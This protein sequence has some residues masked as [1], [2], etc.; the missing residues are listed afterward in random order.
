M[1]TK[2]LTCLAVV[3][4]VVGGNASATPAGPARTDASAVIDGR[5][6]VEPAHTRVQFSVS[7]MGFTHWY[8]DLTEA[9]GS[10]VLDAKDPTASKVEISLPVASV[11]TT[12]SKLD[13]ELRGAQWLDAPTYPTVTFVSTRIV[14]TGFHTAT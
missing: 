6:A 4:C 14:R 5:Y 9:A 8:G 13:E 12:N 2:T 11:S 1:N 7:H 3:A 10:L